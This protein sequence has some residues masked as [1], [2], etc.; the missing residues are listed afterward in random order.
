MDQQK[1]LEEGGERIMTS[2]AIL[3]LILGMV[4]LYGGL[5]ITIAITYKH[6]DQQ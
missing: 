4:I 3:F 5:A 1:T 2:Q 6:K